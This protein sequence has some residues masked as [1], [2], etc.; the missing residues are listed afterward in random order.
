MRIFLMD[1]ARRQPAP[2]DDLFVRPGRRSPRKSPE[3]LEYLKWMDQFSWTRD[4]EV[5]GTSL[6]D[7]L[8]EAYEQGVRAGLDAGLDYYLELA[9]EMLDRKKQ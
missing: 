4:G 1:A 6:D 9:R 8:D 5:I 2:D 7:K 3:R